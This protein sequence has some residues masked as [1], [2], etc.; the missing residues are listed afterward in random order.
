HEAITNAMRSVVQYQEA[1]E[2]IL[3]LPEAE[4]DATAEGAKTLLEPY[5][6][7]MAEMEQINVELNRVPWKGDEIRRLLSDLERL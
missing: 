6:R 4:R 7:I 5:F 2:G 3:E 1:L